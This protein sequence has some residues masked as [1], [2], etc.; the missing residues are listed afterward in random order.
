MERYANRSGDS[1]ITDYEVGPDFVRV[2]FSDGSVY[3]YTNESAGSTN[4]EQ[5]KQLARGGQGLNSFINNTAVRKADAE[6]EKERDLNG[7]RPGR[8]KMT[9]K[10]T[11]WL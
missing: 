10:G 7:G 8:P 9:P 11:D 6:K 2:R 1:G 5:M 4:I 3:R